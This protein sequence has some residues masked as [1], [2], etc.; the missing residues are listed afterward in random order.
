[1]SAIGV[2]RALG[3]PGTWLLRRALQAI[4]T[5]LGASVLVWALLPLAQG[6]TARL[7]LQAQ[8]VTEPTPGQLAQARDDLGLDGSYVE[9]YLHWLAGLLHGDLGVSFASGRPVAHEL[10]ERIP[11]TL[12]LGVA[13]LAIG[14]VLA[15]LLG[16][17][18][19]RFARRWPDYAAQ[20]LALVWASTPSF[21]V[22]L[23]L[24]QILVVNL[25]I[26]HAVLDGSWG[27]VGLPALCLAFGLAD[28]W[29]RLLR[30]DLVAFMASG[31]AESL[32]ARGMGP[33]RIL[34]RHGLP[35]ACLPSLH[36]VAVGI[37][38]LLGG[39]AVIETVFTWPGIGSYAVTSVRTRDLPVIQAF[40]LVATLVYVV[41]S[42]AADAVGGWVDPRSRGAS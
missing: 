12:R 37:A 5:L 10:G 20:G 34:V 22:A 9:Q 19:A 23:V 13:A 25:G 30:S 11:E 38:G 35:N 32:R 39:A 27:E 14:L 40:T 26:G 29:S 17:C 33:T 42:F 4:L 24:V 31:P 16:L 6:D 15:L 36:A 3:A 28:G 21:V 8:G 7:V 1:M 41:S 2:L 18:A